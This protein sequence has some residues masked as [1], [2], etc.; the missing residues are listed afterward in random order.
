M[1]KVKAGIL[2]A[3]GAARGAILT[4]ELLHHKGLL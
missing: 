3:T 2:G 4:A 1:K